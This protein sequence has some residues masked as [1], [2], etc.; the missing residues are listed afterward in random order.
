VLYYICKY[1]TLSCVINF[2]NVRINVIISPYHVKPNF[3][4]IRNIV[5]PKSGPPP[6]FRIVE[7]LLYMSQL[8]SLPICIWYVMLSTVAVRSV[9][10]NSDENFLM[11]LLQTG[12][13][14]NTW[15]VANNMIHFR[16]NMQKI[17]AN[18]G[19]IAWL[20]ARLESNCIVIIARNEDDLKESIHDVMFLDSPAEL[21]R[22]M[23]TVYTRRDGYLL[24]KWNRFQHLL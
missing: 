9:I 4:I 5:Y 10:V 13:L 6:L 22:S 14:T 15:N 1:H 11:C 21:W 8:Q 19:K 2:I 24:V 12:Q 18:R 3:R 23:D 16:S 7:V 20:F 17:H